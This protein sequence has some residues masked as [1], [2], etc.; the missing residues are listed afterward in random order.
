[1]NPGLRTNSLAR[2][3]TADPALMEAR[4]RSWTDRREQL[5]DQALMETFPAS[6]PPSIAMPQDF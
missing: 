5:L 1:M 6:D 3:S 4:R 2:F